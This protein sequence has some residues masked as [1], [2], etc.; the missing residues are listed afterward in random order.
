M[1]PGLTPWSVYRSSPSGHVFR[2]KDLLVFS[3]SSAIS[4]GC[5]TTASGS[6]ESS[7][8]PLP[9]GLLMILNPF[10]ALHSKNNGYYTSDSDGSYHDSC[11][12]SCNCSSAQSTIL[13]TSR[14]IGWVCF[15]WGWRYLVLLQPRKIRSVQNIPCAFRA[16]TKQPIPTPLDKRR[17]EKNHYRG[18]I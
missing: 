2:T 17:L 5:S 11:D 14:N 12:D 8:S 6:W 15:S 9:R 10:G 16:C 13:R 1:V 7:I 18:F 4:F 3:I